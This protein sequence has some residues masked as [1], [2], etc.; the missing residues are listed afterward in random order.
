MPVRLV[1]AAGEIAVVGLARSGSAAARVLA[2][3][4]VRVYASDAGQGPALDAAAA[5]LRE[6]GASAASLVERHGIA[7]VVRRLAIEYLRPLRLDQLV[8]VT[9][10]LLER[11]P[12]SMRLRQT[13]GLRVRIVPVKPGILP[14]YTGKARRVHDLRPPARLG[15]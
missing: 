3:R 2:R 11:R 9:T 14:S 13:L 15:T 4:G 10:E 8:L 5:E 7:F 1:E 6:A 12:A